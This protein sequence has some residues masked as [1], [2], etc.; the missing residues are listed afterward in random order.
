MLALWTTTSVISAGL[1]TALIF[2]ITV[3]R[4]LGAAVVGLVLSGVRGGVAARLGRSRRG[5]RSKRR[6]RRDARRRGRCSAAALLSRRRRARAGDGRRR[7]RRRHAVNANVLVAYISLRTLLSP[8]ALLGRVGATARTLSV[9]LT[10]IGA[11][12]AGLALDALGGAATLALMGAA[13]AITGLLFAFVRTV[14]TARIP[15]PTHAA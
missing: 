3:D 13:L 12:G 8:D 11:L 15:A 6:R 7:V 4:G 2:Y 9:G 5:S 14:R 1:T 10:P